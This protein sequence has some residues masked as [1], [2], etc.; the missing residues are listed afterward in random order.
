MMLMT[1]CLSLLQQAGQVHLAKLMAG[2]GRH[3]LIL[4]EMYTVHG[5][6]RGGVKGVGC[7]YLACHHK[8]PGLDEESAQAGSAE[9]W[10]TTGQAR[11]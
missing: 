11:G 7:L 5:L 1:S 2:G 4:I 3:G 8:A 6:A 10:K 9:E